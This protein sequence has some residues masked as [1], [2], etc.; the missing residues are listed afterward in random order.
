MEPQPG[1]LNRMLN[2]PR[3]RSGAA[4]IIVVAFLVLISGLVIA[5]YSRVGTELSASRSYAEGVNARQ[6][7]DSAIGVVMGQIR[8]AT[9]VTNGAWASQPGMIRVYGTGTDAS[10]SAYAFYK[11]YSSHDLIVSQKEI[12]RF[13][14]TQYDQAAVATAL[15]VPL[16]KGG[17]R[18]QPAFFTDINEPA[19]IPV[20]A[21]DRAK[22]KS[23]TKRFPIFDPSVAAIHDPAVT[24]PAR[25]E[26]FWQV[27]GSEVALP[28]KLRDSEQ[29]PGASEAPMPV[30]WIYVLRDG[31]LTSPT[32]LNGPAAGTTG[33]LAHW[34][35]LSGGKHGV[36]TKT[37]PIV[38]RIAF[39]ADDDSSKVNINTA[40]GFISD[41]DRDED[42]NVK[43]AMEYAGSFWD[44]P[45]VRTVFDRGTHKKT[46]EELGLVDLPGLANC[47]P[48]QNEFQRYPGHP[49][50]TSLDVVLKRLMRQAVP[51]GT[52]N[53]EKLYSWL[54]RLVP[55]G[56]Q[57]GT[58]RL[59]TSIDRELPIKSANDMLD[60]PAFPN[61]NGRTFHMFGSV[62]EM[63]FTPE[64]GQRRLAEQFLD[65]PSN[66]IT[67]GLLDKTRFFLTAH[68]RAPELNLFGRPRVTIWPIWDEPFNS[69]LE[70]AKNNPSDALI[71]F[72]SRVGGRDFIFA[73]KNPYSTTADFNISRNRALME[74]LRLLTASS[75]GKIPGFGGSFEEKLAGATGGRDQLLTE[76]FDYIRTVNLK[77]T[78]RF[79][80][81]TDS[82]QTKAQKDAE[83]AK[84]MYAPKG[85]VVPTR[86]ELGG[87]KVAG[88]GRFPTISE[89]TIVFYHAGWVG[90]LKAKPA[91][92]EALIQDPDTLKDYTVTDKLV[93]A[94]LVFETYNPMQGYAPTSNL[95]G[96]TE[97]LVHELTLNSDFSIASETMTAPAP[98]GFTSK[99]SNNITL[100]SGSAWHGR[101]FGG[102]EGFFHTLK[103]KIPN[104]I[105][106]SGVPASWD[107]PSDPY[108]TCTYA[109]RTQSNSKGGGIDGVRVPVN[110]M[111]F[112]FSGGKA[113]LAIK[114]NDQL[115]QTIKLDFPSGSGWILPRGLTDAE[116]ARVAGTGISEKV[117]RSTPQEFTP[118]SALRADLGGFYKETDLSTKP[119]GPV[120]REWFHSFERRLAWMMYS[121][122]SGSEQSNAPWS[123]ENSGD[124]NYYNDR[125]RNILQPGDTIR[126]LVLGSKEKAELTDPR[127]LSIQ[128]TSENNF[129][130]HPDYASRD[131]ER[132]QTLRCGNGS[133]Y[134][135]STPGS[136]VSLPSGVS[137]PASIAPDL[138]PGFVAQRSD[139]RPA[140]FDTGIGNFPDGGFCGKADEGNVAW[141]YW[142]NNQQK[143]VFVEPYFSTAQYDPPMDT[144]F[145]PNRQVP[146]AVMF[147]S[148]LSAGRGWETLAFCPN[149]AGDNHP[150]LRSPKDHLLLDLFTMPVVEPY[151]ISEPFSTAGKVNLNYQIMPFGYLKRT[152]ALRAAMQSLRVTAIPQVAAP[153]Y[154]T[155]DELKPK[156]GNVRYLVDRDETLRAFED[157]FAEFKTDKSKGFFKSASEICDRFFYPKGD[158]HAGKI[159]YRSKAEIPIKTTFWQNSALTGDNV[160]EKPYAD[161][162]GRLTTKSNTYTVHYRVQTLRQRAPT[163]GADEANYYATWDENRD[164]V[165]AELR[166]NTTIER[167]LD[168]EDK[169]FRTPS[170]ADYIDVEKQALEDAYRFRIL[171]HQRFSPW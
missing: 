83:K 88:F 150:G 156:M 89:A 139:N 93:R 96:P 125:W 122:D 118:T 145:S 44:T 38:G 82:G 108:P 113:Q 90:R 6:L 47:Q 40:G 132:A 101:N 138:V 56:S 27:E 73:R 34:Q 66:T 76:I 12:P 166:G 71:R 116:R 152:T 80:D 41:P 46:G 58:V 128:T 43:G 65:L 106:R 162:Y 25:F 36:P 133:V 115:V 30:R 59:D 135:T 33:M 141:R 74:Y 54:P 75:T 155:Q 117:D 136:L 49:A 67:A 20:T 5:F 109:F 137:Y 17:W 99:S 170:Q 24:D 160:R 127:L 29:I 130:P 55:G 19:L 110:D 26:R 9:T 16:G 14:P 157:F 85:V 52:F 144:Y 95:N 68:S 62:D 140:D 22:G 35:A 84:Y 146:S 1:E 102:T 31:T 151:A 159:L 92:P 121:K 167:Y 164:S 134:F 149:P 114:F 72:C 103:D 100:G 111:R 23:S 158:T 79:K 7:A 60:Y 69:S 50:T 131:A 28:A 143:Y 81:I 129:H 51:A 98:M 169:R 15:E 161:I 3:E 77:D 105:Y 120:K 86:A 32:P 10:A 37:N 18:E 8:E 78:T 112:N 45:R 21:V 168:P 123:T 63:L 64:N 13:D 11:L 87:N 165:L 94:F 126:S 154:K 153:H 91:D 61:L 42:N 148:L 53:S 4:L 107:N 2:R 97:K 163:S 119:R 70:T 142:D 39:W 104:T 48:A 171:H 124:G 57:G 147:G